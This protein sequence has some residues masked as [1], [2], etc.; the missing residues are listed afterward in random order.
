MRPLT[1]ATIAAFER[2]ARLRGA[3]ALHPR[4]A[5]T[6]GVWVVTDP[7]SALGRTLGTGA[8]SAS[9]RL[10]RGA[11][12]PEPLPD[13]HGVGVRLATPEGE[14]DLL[15][16]GTARHLST[17]LPYRSPG[18]LVW[19]SLRRRPSGDYEIGERI[20]AGRR[21]TVGRLEIGDPATDD[22]TP[23]DPYL[24]RHPN[25]APVRLLSR[26]REAAYA[27]SRRGRGR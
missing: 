6:A 17:L 13:V 11:G 9:V 20:P 18:G 21:R 19:L 15:L 25:L 10:S 12:V 24:H 23:Y 8:L 16:S 26:F 2:L 1:A 22:G 27:G 7:T 4:G 14:V 3:R 5:T